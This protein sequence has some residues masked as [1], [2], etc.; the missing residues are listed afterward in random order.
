MKPLPVAMI[1][2]GLLVLAPAVARPA[3]AQEKPEPLSKASREDLAHLRTLGQSFCTAVANRSWICA[4]DGQSLQATD[5]QVWLV[6]EAAC[7]ARD[8][9]SELG[10]VC[11]PFNQLRQNLEPMVLAYDQSQGQWRPRYQLTEKRVKKDV[12]GVP[13]VRLKRSDALE[14]IVE[15]TDPL[16]YDLSRTQAQEAPIAELAELQKLATLLGSSLSSYL[17]VVETYEPGVRQAAASFVPHYFTKQ[18]LSA[19]QKV[20]LTIEGYLGRRKQLGDSLVKQTTTVNGLI[21]GIEEQ[22]GRAVQF[23]QRF[24]TGDR[25]G[26]YPLATLTCVSHGVSSPPNLGQAVLDRA[27]E[28]LISLHVSAASDQVGCTQAVKT[29]VKL[30][31][32]DPTKPAEVQAAVDT[33]D[34]WV[35]LGGCGATIDGV[36]KDLSE[37]AHD[38]ATDPAKLKQVSPEL[39]VAVAALDHVADA[40]QAALTAASGLIAKRDTASKALAALVLF[41][42]RLG[43]AQLAPPDNCTYKASTLDRR[44]YLRSEFKPV[45]WDKTQTHTIKVSVSSPYAASILAAHALETQASY[46]LAPYT[47]QLW[48]IGAA[49]TYTNL[50][51]PVFSAVTDPS[52]ADG[53][54]KVIGK[55]DEKTR[56]GQLALFFNFKPVKAL[57]PEEDSAIQNLGVEVGAGLDASNPAVFAG[58]SWSFGK[59]A[60]LGVGQTYQQVKALRGQSL[61]DPVTGDADIKLRNTWDNSWYVSFSFVLDSLKLFSSGS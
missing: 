10:T 26:E 41:E 51:S 58:L 2:L 28:G 1:C 38:F 39:K 53:S 60:R 48:G 5:G 59:Y 46:T 4:S 15:D 8:L 52:S 29:F 12:A 24:E 18:Q 54:A 19:A 40:D 35:K 49:V 55:T 61:G 3:E 31:G 30:L 17:S 50:A 20:V 43:R 37:E 11:V 32:S 25:E 21:S 23:V 33:F 36:M 57:N 16:L 14:V 7:R 22:T 47:G 27:F 45:S 44:L 9:P 34:S 6:L 42:Q 13:T 56:A